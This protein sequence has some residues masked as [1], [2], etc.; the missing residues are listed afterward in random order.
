MPSPCPTSEPGSARPHRFDPGVDPGIDRAVG[1]LRSHALARLA[2]LPLGVDP[3]ELV[4]ALTGGKLLR[5]RTVLLVA[6]AYGTP[7]LEFATRA[8]AA[9]ELLHAASLV[10]DDIIDG[11]QMRRGRPALHV[12]AGTPT[13]ILV[14]DLLVALAFEIAAPLGERASG[15]LA[16]AFG[17][18]C[19][20]QL[21]ESTLGWDADALP[22][23][24]R[25]AALKTG[26][27]FAAAFQLGAA[28]AHRD[29]QRDAQHSTGLRAAGER[30]GLAFQLLDDL[31]DVR[32][33]AADL[34][35]DRGA[36]L[37]NGIPTLP[38]W[39][40]YRRLAGDEG[41]DGTATPA[42]LAEAAG[43]PEVARLTTARISALV[44]ESHAL[45][46]P[47]DR[48][49]ALDRIFSTVLAGL[50]QFTIDQGIE[51]P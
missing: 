35:K 40:A 15:P 1:L 14:G 5:A 23:I 30:L 48:P 39:S 49:E 50:G 44:E 28:A 51:A 42:R 43:A 29:T 11:S 21:I 41:D 26:A 45:L 38:L 31:R 19:E 24:E 34:G 9:I 4:D 2:P 37:R 10:H 8:A 33:D 12:P 17:H 20:G 7:D 27:L 36:D 47:A 6:H 32:E 18:L 16:I 13:A 3:G 22:G 25:Y 46:P